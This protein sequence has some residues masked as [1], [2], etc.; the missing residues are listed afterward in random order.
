MKLLIKSIL[1]I[2]LGLSL[3]ACP[4]QDSSSPPPQNGGSKPPP[5]VS[6]T[7]FDDFY[8]IYL[9]IKEQTAVLNGVKDTIDRRVMASAIFTDRMLKS[10]TPPTM[11]TYSDKVQTQYL[12]Y[13]N[14]IFNRDGSVRNKP[15]HPQT[16]LCLKG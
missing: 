11:N 1:L 16:K 10:Y 5:A 15:D 2:S 6:C 3:A 9:S 13:F 8:V 12:K 7:S 4:E 14:W